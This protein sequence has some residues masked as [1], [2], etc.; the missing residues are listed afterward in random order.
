MNK[1][2]SPPGDDNQIRCSRLGHHLAF[3]YCRV[4]NKGL[5]CSK[6]MDC[7]Y[8]YFLIEDYLRKEL[9]TEEWE[10]VFNRPVKPKIL[11]LV[12]LIEAAKKRTQEAQ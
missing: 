9:N 10:K 5:P 8:E 1:N 7:W 2:S 12:E 11:S 6:I 4:E 3:S